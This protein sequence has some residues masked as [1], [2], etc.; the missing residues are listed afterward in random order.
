MGHRTSAISKLGLHLISGGYI[1]RIRID[2][3]SEIDRPI[4]RLCPFGE[5]FSRDAVA[6]EFREERASSA[7]SRDVAI[8]VMIRIA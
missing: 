6:A 2:V 5:M 4:W 8:E 3:I 1:I 7:L